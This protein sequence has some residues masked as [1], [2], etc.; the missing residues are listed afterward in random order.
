VSTSDGDA[1]TETHPFTLTVFCGAEC[2]PAGK[3]A[4]SAASIGAA[5]ARHGWR[6]V[7][8]GGNRGLM[9]ALADAV[10]EGGGSAVAVIPGHLVTSESV[11]FPSGVAIERTETMRER[12]ER[13]D[14]LCD[15]FLALP[16]GMGTL[17]ELAEVMT[18][19]QLGVHDRPILVLDLDDFWEPFRAQLQRAV[20]AGVADESILDLAEFLPDV[21]ATVGRVRVLQA[22]AQ[23]VAAASGDQV[24]A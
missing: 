14:T 12:K 13:M 20:D 21:D 15:A 7:F 9:G 18:L 17:E 5:A 24:G 11:I 4:R 6:I 19:R 1:V 23:R 8:G 3:F 22:T 16:G 2:D 10:L